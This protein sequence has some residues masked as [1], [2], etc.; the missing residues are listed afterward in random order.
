MARYFIL[1]FFLIPIGVYAEVTLR[2]QAN[3]KCDAYLNNCI[4]DP[5]KLTVNVDPKKNIVIVGTTNIK[6]DFSNP[7][8]VDFNWLEY[9][10]S[11]NK[12][13]YSATLFN[14]TGVRYGSCVAITP[15][16]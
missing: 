6:A 1:M 12:H 13:E 9:T 11:I 2:C 4:N 10:V 8:V 3:T 15:A 5:Y 14:K 16:W 7:S